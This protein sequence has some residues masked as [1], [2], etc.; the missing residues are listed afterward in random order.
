MDT[1][2]DRRFDFVISLCDKV[3]E[4]C[5]DFPDQPRLIH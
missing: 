5:L 3:R 2:T 4:V 1:L